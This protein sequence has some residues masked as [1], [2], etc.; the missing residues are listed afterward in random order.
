MPDV[1]ICMIDLKGSQEARVADA[2]DQGKTRL[3]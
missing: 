3:R 1:V 2:L